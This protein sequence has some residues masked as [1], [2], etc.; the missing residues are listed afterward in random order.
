MDLKERILLME[1]IQVLKK[2][3][4]DSFSFTISCWK[5]ICNKEAT[6][7]DL[8]ELLEFWKDVLEDVCLNPEDTYSGGGEIIPRSEC[9]VCSSSYTASAKSCSQFM[10]KDEER[11]KI[12]NELTKN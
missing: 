10:C 7:C 12:K 9:G 6:I 5:V 4:L 1:E 2:K 3:A 8:K 11:K